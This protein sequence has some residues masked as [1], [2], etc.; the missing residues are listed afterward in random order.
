MKLIFSILLLSMVSTCVPLALNAQFRPPTVPLNPQHEETI[1]RALEDI[2]QGD[3][4]E[5]IAALMLLGKFPHPASRAALN[6]ALH[7]EEPRVRRAALISVL[8]QSDMQLPAQEA[9]TLLFML[10]DA[11]AEI[12]RQ[13][14]SQLQ[15]I[16]ISWQFSPGAQ[17]GRQGLPPGLAEWSPTPFATRMFWCAEI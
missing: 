7:H 3:L 13:I 4:E 15:R 1:Q 2:A 6:Q 9:R 17:F 16:A 11:D 5:K 14:S 12:R 8:E 10:G